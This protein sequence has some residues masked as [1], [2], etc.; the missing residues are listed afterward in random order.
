[1]TVFVCKTC[2]K[3]FDH[4]ASYQRHINRKTKCKKSPSGSKT[5]KKINNKCTHC[6]KTFSR[7]DSLTRHLKTCK[8]I[9][10]SVFV[11]GDN[12]KIN[13]AVNSKN[14]NNTYIINLIIPSDFTK[15]GIENISAHDLAHMLK[16]EKP[17]M[18]SMIE[19]VNF[20]PNKPQHHN[21]YYPNLSKSYGLIYKN[22]KWMRKEI[23][24][25][26]NCLIDAK[27]GDLKKILDEMSSCLSVE[28]CGKIQL[29]LGK[30]DFSQHSKQKRLNFL[31]ETNI[32]Q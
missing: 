8:K 9:T 13:Y 12:N 4:N 1:M 15:D 17:L 20:N 25:I 26:M 7:K 2:S 28:A 5:S 32:I 14:C 3:Q 21:V 31:R 29:A 22:R 30:S 18:R 23:K 19:C 27:I 10:Q 6:K 24:E 11:N 16:S